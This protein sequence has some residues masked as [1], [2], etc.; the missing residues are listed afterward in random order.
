MWLPH[1]MVTTV[2]HADRLGSLLQE[3]SSV[4]SACCLPPI[5][6]EHEQWAGKQWSACPRG[7]PMTCSVT[8][9]Y[10]V[11][12]SAQSAVTGYVSE[13]SRLPHW[14]G[15][16]RVAR[17]LL[18]WV[19]QCWA[20]CLGDSFSGRMVIKTTSEQHTE[21]T[22]SALRNQGLW[23]KFSRKNGECVRNVN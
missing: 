22:W 23:K 7:T 12:H 9:W 17:T 10:H 5:P 18:G 14:R 3:V 16:S 13:L 15:G 4:H 2:T 21:G 1:P 19:P 6:T 8:A 11:R 20:P